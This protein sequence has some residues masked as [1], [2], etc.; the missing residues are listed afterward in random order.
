MFYL[1]VF[2]HWKTDP[3]FDKNTRD[4]LSKLNPETDKKEIEDR[5]Y[6]NLDFG[7]GGLRG[8]MGAGTNRMN[9]YTVGKATK[10][11]GSYLLTTYGREAEKRG[12]V[13][14]YDTRNNSRYFAET[15]A[16]VLSNMGIKVYL[17]ANARPTP[18]LS[19]SVRFWNAVAGVMVTASHNPKEYNGYKVYNEFGCQ[20][21]PQQAE[22]VIWYVNAVTDYKTIDFTGNVSLIQLGDVTDNFIHAVIKQ[23]RN[24]DKKV[25]ADLNIIYTPLHG[26]GNVPVT[27]CLLMDGFKQVH[28][29]DAQVVPDGN[30]PT[31]ESP[32]PEDPRALLL[33]IEQAE[34]I[35][36]D[37]VLGTDPDGDRVGVAV[38]I[39][40]GYQMLTG[41]QVGALLM[42]YVLSH[43]DLNGIRNP[44]VIKTIVTSELGTEI[45]KKYGLTV[46]STLTGFKFIGEKI[47]QFEQA[48]KSVESRGRGGTKQDYTFVFGYEESYGYLAGTHARDKDVV[49]SSLLIC[50]MAAEYKTQDKTLF[51]RM[52]ELYAEYGY[53]RDA[54]DRFTLKGKDGLEKISS[55]MDGLRNSKSP[56]EETRE[57]IDYSIPVDAESGFGTLPTSN[58]LKYILKDGS[59]VAVRPSGTEPQIK[60]Y[61]SVRAADKVQ[62]EAR[63]KKLQKTIQNRLG[64]GE[65]Q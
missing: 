12:V 44:A 21:V 33:G 6:Q 2:N 42:D 56:F 58:A 5:F 51:D 47:T 3:F 27:K 10:G 57:K 34:K 62:A 61:Y 63:L 52:N 32:N 54:L 15:T 17:H 16:N 36:A 53:Y 28:H 18:Q 11:L 30:F 38:K 43:T 7:T 19:F 35:G 9:K 59:W 24:H 50:E 37:I 20:L 41:N 14:G 64:L 23:S 26:T 31:V 55:M 45:A 65:G 46:F 60:I 4:E 48:R 39:T 29:V 22:Q 1:D 25:K 13:I 40:D 8:I 49:V